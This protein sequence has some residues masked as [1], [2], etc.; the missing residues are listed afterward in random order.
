[1]HELECVLKHLHLAQQNLKELIHGL[2]DERASAE[3]EERE[4][5]SELQLRLL[6]VLARLESLTLK[7]VDMH[8]C[9]VNSARLSAILENLASAEYHCTERAWAARDRETRLALL[10]LGRGLRSLRKA[11]LAEMFGPRRAGQGS[12]RRG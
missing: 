9:R 12:P 4:R 6:D 11:L 10:E 1:M 2:N 8:E 5:V 3:G 7:V